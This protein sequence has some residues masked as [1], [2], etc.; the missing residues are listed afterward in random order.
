M[1]EGSPLVLLA[2]EKVSHVGKVAEVAVHLRIKV[3]S[4]LPVLLL[5]V[6]A[7]LLELYGLEGPALEIEV[8]QVLLHPLQLLHEPRHPYLAVRQLLLRQLLQALLPLLNLLPQEP[9]QAGSAVR[10]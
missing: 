7:Q 8:G 3:H 9:R 2:L 5:E 4:E 10:V 6:L 1:Q